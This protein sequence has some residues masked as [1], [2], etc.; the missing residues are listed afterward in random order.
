MPGNYARIKVWVAGEVLTAA[1]Q[2]AEFN[3]EIN[4]AIPASIDDYSA[5][6]AQMRS[7]A[8]PGEVGSES[9]PTTLAG[10]FERMRFT[11]REFKQVF[12]AAI[13]QWY[14][15]VS[16]ALEIAGSFTA[17]GAIQR[18]ETG[19]AGLGLIRR[20]S[21]GSHFLIFNYNEDSTQ[22]DATKQSWFVRLGGTTDHVTIGRSPA[23]STTLADLLI[24]DNTGKQTLG[25]V[26]LNRI[27]FSGSFTTASLV[28]GGSDQRNIAHGLGTDEVFVLVSFD[29][30]VNQSGYVTVRGPGPRFMVP[31][32]G[33]GGSGVT[34]TATAPGSGSVRFLTVNDDASGSRTI[35]VR[36]VI[37]PLT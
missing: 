3:N 19:A 4:N 32:K 31:F 24:W 17:R 5:S 15:T 16:G 27:G 9:L 10:E 35:T 34:F 13:A 33:G 8:D 14:E 30:G 21:T 29:D 2:N 1:D 25:S 18:K 20:T 12:K 11:I 26:P 37:L 28:Y 7:V 22:Q 36:Y 6:A 23:G